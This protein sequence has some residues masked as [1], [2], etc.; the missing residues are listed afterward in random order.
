M[1]YVTYMKNHIQQVHEKNYKHKCI[2]CEKGFQKSSDL[3]DHLAL[4]HLEKELYK[5]SICEKSF[6]TQQSV[7]MHIKAIH[8]RTIAGK[9]EKCGKSFTSNY[10]RHIKLHEN[11]PFCCTQNSCF[12]MFKTEINL[13]NHITVKHTYGFKCDQCDKSYGNGRLLKRHKKIKH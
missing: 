10:R 6:S 7:E 3:R 5:C 9:C 8:K 13:K 11:N 1:M 12:K 2:V 4:K